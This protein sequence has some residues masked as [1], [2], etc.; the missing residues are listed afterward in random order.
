MS[1]S[2]KG[3]AF[4]KK[5]QRDSQARGVKRIER[6]ECR[7]KKQSSTKGEIMNKNKT[8]IAALAGFAVVAFTSPV[9]AQYKPT[10][11]DGIT[12]SPKVRYQLDDRRAGTTS[13]AAPAPTMACPKCKDAWVEQTDRG[14][15]G[16]AGAKALTGQTTKL[17]AHH[18]C[19]GCSTEW[20]IAGTGR[21][22]HSVATHKCTGCGA[23]NLVCCGQKGGN[24]ATKGMEQQPQVAPLK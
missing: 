2:K 16:F 9:L 14:S 10:G 15:R 8:L 4:G 6:R 20:S 18:L 24:I 19:D 11:D 12:A 3:L 23:E 17:V 7:P 13:I 1:E 5:R 21:G 22:K